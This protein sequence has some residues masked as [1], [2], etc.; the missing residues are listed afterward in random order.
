MKPES[1]FFV[2][3]LISALA[4][5]ACTS[6]VPPQAPPVAAEP[7]M[8]RVNVAL[9]PLVSNGPLFIAKEE[10]YFAR[11]G[12][13]VEFVKFQNL[14]ASLPVLVDGK[15][16]V[17]GGP[18]LPGIVNSIAKEANV[19]IVAEKGKVGQEYCTVTAVV[20]RRDLYEKGIVRNVSDLKG[21]KIMGS[22]E[23]QYTLFRALALG[24]L[25]ADDVEIV[26]MDYP[27]ALVALKN[28]A[29]DAGVLTEPYLTQAVTSG[30]GVV[31]V[32]AQNFIPDFPYLL[33]YGPAILDKDPEL[34]KRFMVA[35]LQGAKQF[36]Q[37]KT[38]RN[39][40]ILQNYSALDRDLLNQSCWVKVDETGFVSKNAV[41]D[42]IDWMFENKNIP[43]KVDENKLYDMSYAA[44][45]S[46]VLQNT[47]KNR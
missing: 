43:Q 21:R 3:L 9:I 46:G 39:L 13:D 45:A 23:Q 2:F 6:Q 11:Q 4:V 1:L 40:A 19:R 17:T 24:N 47:T 7:E 8:T 25:T 15:I 29:L 42:Y 20:V 38:E 10:G 28:Q 27:S 44:Y 16:G 12:I 5:T 36:N 33:Y 32:P 22:S 34:G 30:A 14:A 18:L 26:A 31:L 41:G 35:Y 37:G